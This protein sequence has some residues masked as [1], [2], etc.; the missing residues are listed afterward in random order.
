MIRRALNGMRLHRRCPDGERGSMAILLMVV[1]VGMVL[2]AMIVPVIITQDRTTKFDATRVQALDAA[3]SGIDITMGLLRASVNSAT[4]IGDSAKLP[5]TT[6]MSPITGFV[7]SAGIASYSLVIEYFTFDPVTEAYPSNNA[8]KCAPGKGTYDTA[9]DSVTPRFARLTSLGTVVGAAVNGSTAGRTLTSTYRFRTSDINF[10]GGLIK[11]DPASLSLCMDVGAALPAAGTGVYL[12]PCIVSNPPAPL[13]VF[14]YRTDLTLQL[15]STAPSNAVNGCDRTTPTNCGLCLNTAATPAVAGNAVQLSPC[16]PL[17][18]PKFYTQQWSFNDDGRYQVALSTSVMTAPSSSTNNDNLS[19]LCITTAGQSANVPL[20]VDSCDAGAGGSPPAAQ[21]WVPNAS[22]GPGAATLPQWVNYSDVGGC[23]DIT[24]GSITAT[25]LDVYP[26]K[27]NP[28]PGS[29]S[30]TQQFR[31]PAI[32]AGQIT[33][34]S[35][36]VTTVPSGGTSCLTSPGTNGGY[37]TMQACSG[38]SQQTWTMYNGDKTLPYS[39]KYQIVSG[40]LCLGLTAPYGSE[41]W[42]A[43]VVENCSGATDQ[44]WNANASV[45]GAG[46][47]DTK[48]K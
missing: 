5:C 29:I 1:L 47:K 43:V 21:R 15:S 36:L 10:P 18:S 45:L 17:G 31:A 39:S 16:G 41:M 6:P 38:S 7:N 34:T 46:L 32:P 8:M 19:V 3:E 2:S 44:K 27:Q 40:G 28:H 23:L 13:Q 42:A 24:A 25:H 35:Q 9:S 22:V 33:V 12:K 30:W 4:N 26:C 11:V 20:T 14:T 48:E 37:V